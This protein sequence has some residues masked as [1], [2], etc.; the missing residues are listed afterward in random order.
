VFDATNV[1]FKRVDNAVIEA[2][3][4]LIDVLVRE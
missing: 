2:A 3:A 1:V 4:T